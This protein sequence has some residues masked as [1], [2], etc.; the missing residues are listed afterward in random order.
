MIK[1]LKASPEDARILAETRRTVWEETYRGIYPDAM[2]DGYDVAHYTERDRQ[3][4]EDPNHVYYLFMDG[5]TCV[6]YFSFGPY[7][8]GT[9]KN[10]ALCLNNLY[11]LNSHK[12]IG[13]GQQA[14]HVIRQYCRDCEIDRFF[15]GCNANNLPAVTFYRHMGGI[16]GDEVPLDVPPQDQIIHFEFYL[17]E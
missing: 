14:F 10:F 11:I 5:Q 17:G 15:C 16:Q 7:N 6:G 3:R 4:L 2:L 13:L 1:M 9:Y 12:G 8:Y